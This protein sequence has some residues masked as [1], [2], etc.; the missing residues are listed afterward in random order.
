MLAELVWFNI[1][2][3]LQLDALINV[4]IENIS[5]VSYYGFRVILIL[6]YRKRNDHKNFFFI[7]F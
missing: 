5:K 2:I 1:V 4:E 6:Y 3:S 7:W